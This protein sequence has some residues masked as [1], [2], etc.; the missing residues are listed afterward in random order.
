MAIA[1]LR[2]VDVGYSNISN[3]KCLVINL[4]EADVAYLDRQYGYTELSKA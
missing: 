4:T 2:Y 1:T 3:S